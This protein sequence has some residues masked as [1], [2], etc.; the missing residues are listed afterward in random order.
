[1]TKAAASATPVADPEA[2]REP[3]NDG[4][5]KE[6]LLPVAERME[7]HYHDF[8]DQYEQHLLSTDR[9][10]TSLNELLKRSNEEHLLKW[11]PEAAGTPRAAFI[12]L[13][14]QVARK[15]APF[16]GLTVG[17]STFRY[18]DLI[19][20][21]EPPLVMEMSTK[22]VQ[23]S[24]VDYARGK[25]LVDFLDD[26]LVRFRPDTLP[27]HAMSKAAFDFTKA[28]S[29]FTPMGTVIP[30]R[31]TGSTTIASYRFLRDDEEILWYIQ[32]RHHSA[33]I[34]AANS[35][36]TIA[37]LSGRQ[38]IAY[39]SGDMLNAMEHHL[40]K[41]MMRYEDGDC[42][43]AGSFMRMFLHRDTIAFQFG[44]ATFRLIRASIEKNVNDIRFIEL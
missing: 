13:A 36:A 25:S 6:R 7:Q 16:M 31:N 44:E 19:D 2:T 10:N 20:W 24:R 40:L 5:L 3:L 8:L 43:Q 38:D 35:I 39:G 23:I 22:D 28:F 42:F 41:S 1:M 11:N 12:A 34:R 15:A 37:L 21:T 29:I 17:R 30:I 18:L 27:K 14:E 33:V 9:I 26:L 4:E 32:P